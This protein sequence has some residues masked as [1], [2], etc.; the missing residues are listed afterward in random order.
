MFHGSFIKQDLELNL[1]WFGPTESMD[2][3]WKEKK[4][5]HTHKTKEESRGVYEARKGMV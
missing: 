5:T 3:R 4:K 1:D 2:I